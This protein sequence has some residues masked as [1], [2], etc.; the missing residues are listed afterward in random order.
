MYKKLKLKDKISVKR[1]ELKYYL[2]KGYVFIEAYGDAKILKDIKHSYPYRFIYN[3]DD[4]ESLMGAWND[5]DWR[6]CKLPKALISFKGLLC[7]H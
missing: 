5:N 7:K 3:D 6:V 4:N 2:D 1:D